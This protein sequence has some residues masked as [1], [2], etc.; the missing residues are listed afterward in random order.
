[1]TDVHGSAEGHYILAGMHELLGDDDAYVAALAASLEHDPG[2]APARLNLAIRLARDGYVDEA[3]REMRQALEDN[4]L[5][6]LAHFNYALLL[7]G[8]GRDEE[9]LAHLRRV[10]ELDPE[11]WAAA[12]AELALLLDLE[13]RNEAETVAERIYR[14]CKNP[15]VQRQ[16]QSLME[17][18]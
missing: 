3:E 9:A 10:Q 6:P 8:S 1:M 2:F 14:D 13:R 16:V 17:G 18:A 7:G 11:S 12:I 5:Y 4:P 15:E